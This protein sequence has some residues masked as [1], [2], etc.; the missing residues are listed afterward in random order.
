MPR[1]LEGICDYF[2]IN[3]LLPGVLSDLAAGIADILFMLPMQHPDKATALSGAFFSGF[4]IG[5]LAA[6]LILPVHPA[7]SGELVGLL[8]R[9]PDAVIAKA[10]RQSLAPA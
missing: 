6:N 2:P 8:V 9:V 5:F 4:A 7:L 10:T 1:A 3:R